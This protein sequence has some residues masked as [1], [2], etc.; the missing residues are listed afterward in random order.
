MYSSVT[1]ETSGGR[2]GSNDGTATLESVENRS[3]SDEQFM[4]A[5]LE[6]AAIAQSHD[7]VPVGAVLV[8]D[9]GIIAR[10]H[11][12][13]VLDSDPSG[14]AEIV[15]MREAAK[16]LKNH[17]LGGCELFVTMEPC[18]MCAGAIVHARI[19]RLVYGASDPKTGAV[20]SVLQVVN[21]PTLNHQT[22]VVSGVFADECGEIVRQFFRK[23]RE[24]T[25]G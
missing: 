20:G 17:R 23:K 24:D 13:N 12:R 7:E 25:K 14:H 5:A 6:Q 15:V 21:H 16:S 9:G 2:Y 10:A 8:K 3:Q 11:N 1:G 22:E 18:A 4:R 19:A